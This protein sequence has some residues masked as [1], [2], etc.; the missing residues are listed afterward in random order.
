MF[1]KLLHIYG[2]IW[3]NSYGFMVTLGIIV[4]LFLSI[5]HP[6]REKLI[7]KSQFTDVLVLGIISG[8]V[9]GRILFILEEFN[10]YKD[11]WLE[12]FYPWIGGFSSLGSILAVLLVSSLFLYKHKISILCF[13]DLIC[14]HAPIIFVFGR[15]GCFLAGC[16]YGVA[17]CCSKFSI[18]Y[19]HPE[20]IAPLN[21]ALYPTQLIESL[22]A[23]LIFF[24]LRFGVIR[25]F[26]KKG[27]ILFSFLILISFMRFVID[28]WR[29][30]WGPF[31]N[32]FSFSQ[33]VSGGIFVISIIGLLFVSRSKS[34]NN[35]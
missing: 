29:G 4:F 11:N 25:I 24:I 32:G 3:I 34:V 16:C 35:L 28:F 30:D 1:P 23:L 13:F 7:S 19:T 8:I 18:I 14:M 26:F 15:I 27:Q 17:A 6:L 2:P 33:V 5:N 9:G 21:I 22:G 10:A 20:S 12:A 31:F